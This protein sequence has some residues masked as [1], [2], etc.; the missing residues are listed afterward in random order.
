MLPPYSVNLSRKQLEFLKEGL[1]GT[2]DNIQL[3]HEKS[4]DTLPGN[5]DENRAKIA[6]NIEYFEDG[7]LMY[8][9]PMSTACFRTFQESAKRVLL[10]FDLMGKYT[11]PNGNVT[12]IT[13][14]RVQKVLSIACLIEMY[15]AAINSTKGATFTKHKDVLKKIISN[16]KLDDVNN[17]L[18]R[19]G[20]VI[21]CNKPIRNILG[22]FDEIENEMMSVH[23]PPSAMYFRHLTDC[24]KKGRRT[25]FF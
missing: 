21:S 17:F 4:S 24:H 25:Y 13:D 7:R 10:D 2:C 5:L 15:Y 18:K 6:V 1:N 11:N 22:D 9:I 23:R 3:V 12:E 19:S 16:F 8:A 20:Y 14:V